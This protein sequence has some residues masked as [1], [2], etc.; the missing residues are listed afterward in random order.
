M[1]IAQA[2]R[3]IRGS[4]GSTQAPSEYTSR[5][6]CCPPAATCGKLGS[7]PCATWAM[8]RRAGSAG[9]RPARAWPSVRRRR[10]AGKC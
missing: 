3:A 2:A 9:Q 5:T 7:T 8:A 6:P 1:A 4:S 10:R